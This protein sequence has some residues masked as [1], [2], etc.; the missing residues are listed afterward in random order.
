MSSIIIIIIISPFQLWSLQ[1]Q[2]VTHLSSWKKRRISTARGR[3]VLEQNLRCQVAEGFISR[4]TPKV[5][6]YQ[7]PVDSPRVDNKKSNYFRGGEASWVALFLE[8]QEN[9]VRWFPWRVS[10]GWSD[11]DKMRMDFWWHKNY[12]LKWWWNWW[13]IIPWDPKPD[14]K[15]P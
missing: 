7:Q 9:S 10:D 3:L 2:F 1:E 5:A 8:L 12:D 14:P 13:W 4:P 11:Y 6:E 15:S